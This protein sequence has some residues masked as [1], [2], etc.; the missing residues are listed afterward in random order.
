[1]GNWVHYCID[2]RHFLDSFQLKKKKALNDPVKPYLSPPGRSMAPA[3]KFIRFS[4]SSR[5][6]VPPS[7]PQ[8]RKYKAIAEVL[9]KAKHAVVERE[10]YSD[11]IC[12]QCRSGDRPDEL[13][14]CDKCDNGFHMNCLRPIVVKLPMGSWLCPGCCE[15]RRVRSRGHYRFDASILCF[16]SVWCTRNL[17]LM[18]V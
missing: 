6:A 17:F 7:P 16:L 12:E 8:P 11:V 2:K 13:L 18:R 9:A 5:R 15:H 3:R 1:M 10:S 14:L 4:G